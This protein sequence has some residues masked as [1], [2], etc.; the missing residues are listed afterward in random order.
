MSARSCST[1]GLLVDKKS[2]AFPAATEASRRNSRF[3]PPLAFL[4][5][6]RRPQMSPL[7]V[8]LRIFPIRPRLLVASPR[9]SHLGPG[10]TRACRMASE[11]QKGVL[12]RR[13]RLR[14][15][16]E[17]TEPVAR[18]R[19]R[20]ANPLRP[21]RKPHLSSELRILVNDRAAGRGRDSERARTATLTSLR[22]AIG[23]RWARIAACSR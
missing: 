12:A 6:R 5:A 2:Q 16:D 23:R 3:G 10:R 17:P 14:R 9:R 22:A 18:R 15:P 19:D 8:T 13:A 7:A 20:R 1:K 11:A 21:L 4:C